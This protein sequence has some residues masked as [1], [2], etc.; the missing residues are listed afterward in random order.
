MLRLG[1]PNKKEGKLIINSK[2]RN[3]VIVA[4]FCWFVE[5]APRIG[6]ILQEQRGTDQ[7]FV[8]W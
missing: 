4:E 1:G 7:E 3:K 5:E 8:K 2:W 6:I